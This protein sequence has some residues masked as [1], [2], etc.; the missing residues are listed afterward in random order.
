[1]AK[2]KWIAENF[3]SLNREA[4]KGDLS[5]LYKFR[6]GNYRVLYE[7]LENEKIIIVHKIDHRR[8]IHRSR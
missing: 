3:E 1:M 2:L 4:L 5:G 6:I 8:E 7:I